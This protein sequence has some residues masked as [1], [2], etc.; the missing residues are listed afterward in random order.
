MDQ[1]PRPVSNLFEN[2]GKIRGDTQVWTEDLSICST[3]E[4]YPHL[5]YLLLCRRQLP[6]SNLFHKRWKI[7]TNPGLNRGSLYL[8][9]SALSL[10]SWRTPVRFDVVVQYAM[11]QLPLPLSNLLENRGKTRGDTRVWTGDL[12]ICSRMLYHWAI[13]PMNRQNKKQ[14]KILRD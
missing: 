13:S 6:L 3:T 8:Q 5:W 11:H 1:L 10:D 9:L 12:S 2:K 14:L 4:L 7:L